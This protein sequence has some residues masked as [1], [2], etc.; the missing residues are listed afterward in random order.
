M[1]QFQRNCVHCT[2]SHQRCVFDANSPSQCKRCIKLEMTCLFKLSSQGRRNDLITS[3]DSNNHNWR[4]VNT[5]ES[6]QYRH[7]HDGDSCHGR[8]EEVVTGIN[9]NS[10]PT[11]TEGG[12]CVDHLTTVVAPGIVVD[13]GPHLELIKPNINRGNFLSSQAIVE[14]L[15]EFDIAEKNDKNLWKNI[16]GGNKMRKWIPDLHDIVRRVSLKNVIENALQGYIKIVQEKYPELIYWK[17]GAI[18]SL[19]WAPSQFEGHGGKLHSDYAHSLENLEPR[20]RPVSIIVGLNHFNFMW[21]SDR[22]SRETEIREMTV[23]PGQMIIFTNHCLHAGGKNNTNEDQTRLFAYLVSDVSH[24]P[25]GTVTTW[26]WQRHCED[27]LI[28][29][30]SN[31]NNSLIN[32]SRDKHKFRLKTGRVASIGKNTNIANDVCDD[33]SN[34]IDGVSL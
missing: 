1:S 34:I 33:D 19:P 4:S 27:P 28:N 25:S 5:N 21:L 16:T 18:K 12:G 2:G 6:V 15:R 29:K 32:M 10:I 30:P 26:D 3:T 14:V 31:S 13:N 17:V 24:F 23:F 8:V 11:L 20:L 7:H 22:K 9:N